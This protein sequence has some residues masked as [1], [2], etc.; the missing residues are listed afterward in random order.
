MVKLLNRAKVSTST[1][2]T[3]T[4]TLGSAETGYQSF[5]S[6]GA[7]NGDTISFVI[8]D[9]DAWEISTGTYTSSGT[10]LSRTLVESSTGSL[11]SL[12][13]SAI[14]FST[15]TSDD[16]AQPSDIS[17]TTTTATTSSAS[18]TAIANYSLSSY[19][20]AKLLIKAKRES[21]G[22]SSS[23]F[24]VYGYNA[25]WVQRSVDISA[26]IG[27]TVRLIFSHQTAPSGTTYR[28]DLQL[29]E[30]TVNG[31]TYTFETSG[32]LTGW[33]TST[34]SQSS[35][36][37]VSWAAVTTGT[38][39]QRWLRDS[40]GTSSS[41]T[42]L[43]SG[44]NNTS[45]YLYTETS[46]SSNG[47]YY[48]LKSPE[49]TISSSVLTFY[50]ARYGSTIGHFNV[51]VEET[52]VTET[53]VSELLM[54]NDGTNVYATEYGQIYTSGEPVATFDVDILGGNMRLLVTPTST[55]NTN[56]TIKEIAV[57]A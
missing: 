15:A 25:A 41:G 22:I 45:F 1:T 38:S 24:N 50:E 3:G 39:G 33:E 31:S 48:W 44:G 13:G 23:L 54:V 42:G 51:Y 11:L 56:Y 27:K 18:Q 52:P 34:S 49:I 17:V 53:Q 26:Y 40:G 57:D 14:V 28:A 8:E 10:T 30:I 35:Y 19:D 6:A 16:I 7:I 5:S 46:G 37:N 29:D 47:F 2:G 20:A 32:D 55:T 43:T 12:S 36:D 4:I 9:G 21:G